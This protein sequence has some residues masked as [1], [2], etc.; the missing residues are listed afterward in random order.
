MPLRYLRV[1]FLVSPCLCQYIHSLANYPTAFVGTQAA[2]HVMDE[3]I[4]G[5]KEKSEDIMREVSMKL[6][7]LDTKVLELQAIQAAIRRLL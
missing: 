4:E 7:E 6:N 3:S 2:T 5:L 1:R